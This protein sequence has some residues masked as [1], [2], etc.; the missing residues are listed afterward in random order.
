MASIGGLSG[1]TSSSLNGLKGY[2]GLASG[3]D[4]DS[5]IEGMTQG[6]TSKIYK[7]QQKKDLLQWEQNAIRG[8]TDKMI[9]FADKYLSTYSSSTNLFSNSFWGRNLITALGAN[10]KY[11]SVSGTSSTADTLSILGV[12][13]LARKAQMTSKNPASDRTLE[14][15][16]IDPLEVQKAENLPGSTIKINYADKNYTITLPSGK[17]ADGKEYKYDTVANIADSLNRAFK[18]IEVGKGKKLSEVLQ[19]ETSGDKIVFKD[20][21]NAGN[22]LKLTGGSALSYLGFKDKPDSEFKEL[23]IT[24]QGLSSVRDITDDDIYTKTSFFDRIA[25]KELTFTYN[26]TSKSIKMPTKEEL[27]R[28]KNDSSYGKTEQERI[29]KKLTESMQDQLDDAFGA[30]RVK[31]EAKEDGKG[32]YSL[33]FQTTTPDGKMDQSS[34]LSISSG[35]A[36][37]LGA[38][39]AFKMNYGESNR[40]N[41]DAK[42]AESGL[43][44]AKNMTFPATITINGKSIEVKA[45]DTVRTLMDKINE[46]D[47]GV[48]VTYQNS[49]DS[50]V[51]SATAN[52]AS[53]KIDVGG[54]FAKIFGEF[55]KTDGQDAIVTVKYAGSDQTVDLIR[56]S[57]S[58]KVDGMTISVNGE[59]GYVKDEATGEL[60]LDPSAEAVTFDAKVD[61]DKIVETVKKMV[62]EYNE[63]I[64]LV[65]KETGTKPKRDYPPLTSAQKKELSESEIEAW[66]EKAK[67][68]LLFNDNDL[69]GLSN[70]LR[71]V[72]SP[73]D[74]AALKKIGLTTSSTTSDNGKISFDENAF[75]AALKSDPE[76]VKEMF[77]KEAVKD[78]N[79]NVV[80]QAGIAVNM[81]TAFDKY[82]KT[83]GEPKGILIER[84]GSIKSPASI[85]QNAIYKQLEEID[86]R[87]ESLQDTLK[88]EQDR[89]IKQFTA[90]ESVIAQMNSQSSWLSQFGS[91]Y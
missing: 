4:R 45:E 8:I 40:V 30:G 6:T 38:N 34:I 55:N 85:T 28:A 86:A 47:A 78:E 80:S 51:F 43:A 83:L 88:M 74:Q 14:T 70:S 52:G 46:A 36:G 15:G 21:E 22:I 2:G 31:V 13:Q 90:L 32:H 39:G 50:F 37:L 53:G 87:I 7:Q 11:V 77:T 10:S 25:E 56:D 64:E 62:E 89:Y 42:I 60:K 58:F 9:G 66:E 16:A 61:E 81:K 72:L 67:E 27:E 3:L 12:K 69:K 54:G 65:N 19:V 57:N 59:F 79:G 1:T 63:I 35:D 68:G 71:F 18:D 48:Q 41:M 84:A 23:D 5:L 33:G 26:G 49:S 75:R 20:K 82:A 24:A 91:G 73:A 76:G 17:D 44:G 29:M